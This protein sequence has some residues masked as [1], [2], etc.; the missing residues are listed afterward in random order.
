MNIT[1]NGFA[2]DSDFIIKLNDSLSS[3]NAFN[4]D[5]FVNDKTNTPYSII[6]TICALERNVPTNYNNPK[7]TGK[8]ISGFELVETYE[9][10]NYVST[11]NEM[12][13]V[14]YLQFEDMEVPLQKNYHEI[15][16]KLYGDYMAMPPMEKRWNASPVVLDLGDGNGNVMSKDSVINS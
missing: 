14:V 8:H 4:Y 9:K 7:N 5:K 6:D 10:I 1:Y 2:Y 13:P 12:F 15:M 11:Y 16:T 3:I